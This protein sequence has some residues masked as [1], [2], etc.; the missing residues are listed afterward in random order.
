[1]VGE[2]LRNES[3]NGWIV[4]KF[5]GTSV[6]KFPDKIADDIIRYG[7]YSSSDA[8]MSHTLSDRLAPSRCAQAIFART[9]AC[10][11]M[12][13]AKYGQEGYRNHKQ[14]GLWASSVV[15]PQICEIF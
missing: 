2:L 11:R 14:V 3:S 4:Q 7:I 13:R 8:Y 1:M 5:G 12:L 10:C 6:G 15:L 9:Q